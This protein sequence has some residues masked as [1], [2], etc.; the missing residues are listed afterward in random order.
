[1]DPLLSGYNDRERNKNIDGKRDQEEKSDL[2]LTTKKK[3]HLVPRVEQNHKKST[4]QK[5]WI[6]GTKINQREEK[7]D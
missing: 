1:M 7:L 3:L 2:C 5:N 6:R 4:A